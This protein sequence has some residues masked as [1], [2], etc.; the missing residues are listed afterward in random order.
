MASLQKLP[1]GLL[2]SLVKVFPDAPPPV[3]NDLMLTALLGE[4]VSFQAAIF[5]QGQNRRV[6]QVDVSSPI[7][8]L[9]RVRQ[10]ENVPAAYPAPVNPDENYLRTQPGLY[11]DLLRPLLRGQEVYLAPGQWKS[12]WIDVEISADAP[13]GCFPITVS[14]TDEEGAALGSYTAQIEIINVLL[15][16]QELIHTEWFHTDCLADY[17]HVPAFSEE[18]WAIIEQFLRVA[19]KRGV[20]SILTPVF[21]PPLD[22][23]VGGERTTVQLVDISLCNGAYIFGFDKLKR[24]VKLCRSVGIRYFEI[25]HLFTQWGARCAPKIVCNVDGVE[26]RIFGWD[27]PATGGAYEAFLRAFLPALTE[28]LCALGI[29]KETFFHISDEPSLE[30][31]DSYLAAKQVVAPYLESFPIIDALSNFDFYEQGVVQNPVPAT[32]HIEPFL[33]HQVPNLWCYYCCG[34]TRNVSNRFIAMPSARNRILGVQLFLYQIAGFLHW[35]FNFYNTMQSLEHINPYEVTDGGLAVPAGDPFVVYPGPGGI[36]EESIRLMVFDELLAD[37][38]AF[39]LLAQRKG[40]AHVISLIEKLAGGP[41]TFS[42]Y[43]QSDEFI[44]SLREQVNRELAQCA[45]GN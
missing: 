38:R 31:L 18:H 36:P 6:V 21:T 26:K 12:V 34:Q 32:D 8:H 10:V 33:Q 35:G 1:G 23:A 3:Q 9:V 11:P 41:V 2:S 24:W 45:Q 30:H 5:G 13:V 28:Q 37:L 43:P 19:V 40:R 4:T 17:Y 15:P 7:A 42:Q 14:F 44:L 27:T 29:E 39:S 25:S 22:T 16:A 20:N